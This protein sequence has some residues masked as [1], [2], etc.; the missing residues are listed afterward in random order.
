MPLPP[1]ASVSAFP[2]PRPPSQAL[3]LPS[4]A[5]PTQPS[6]YSLVSPTRSRYSD[7]ET[8]APPLLGKQVRQREPAMDC[9]FPCLGGAKKKEKQPPEKPQIRPA[10]G[11]AILPNLA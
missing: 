11:E 3:T 9:C 8:R 5:R 1:A 4:E 2:L 7:A 10:S 6:F